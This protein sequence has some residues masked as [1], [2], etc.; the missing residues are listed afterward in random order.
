MVP[1]L[2]VFAVVEAEQQEVA[3]AADL[4][5]HPFDLFDHGGG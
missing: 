3:E 5:V 1:G 4:L 2:R